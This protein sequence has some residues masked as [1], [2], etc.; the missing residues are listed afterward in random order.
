MSERNII[1]IIGAI[2]L[3]IIALALIYTGHFEYLGGVA[4]LAFFLY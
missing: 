1:R 4:L 2:C 3:T